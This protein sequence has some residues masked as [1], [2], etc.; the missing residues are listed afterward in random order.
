MLDQNSQR[1]C[2]LFAGNSGAGK[3]AAADILANELESR[4][5][6]TSRTAFADPIKELAVHLLGIPKSISYGSQQDKLDFEVYGKSARQ[7]LQ[8]IGTEMG[9]NQIHTDIWIHRFVERALESNARVVIGSDLRFRNEMA[10]T[11]A[12]LDN[13]MSMKVV[14]I[15]NP[16]VPV[17]LEHQSEREIYNTPDDAFDLV[18]HNTKG[19][20]DLRS[21]IMLLANELLKQTA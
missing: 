16:R 21:L 2:V 1:L 6:S 5:C 18:I 20:K 9:R 15:I 4:G 3:D 7:H 8:W 10:V 13:K 17:N 12:M 14:K 11:R 19:L